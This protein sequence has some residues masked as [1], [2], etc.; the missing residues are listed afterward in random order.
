MP[1][2][3]QL[4]LVHLPCPRCDHDNAFEAAEVTGP[5]G[6]FCVECGSSFERGLLARI[7]DAL[8]KKPAHA[9]AAQIAQGKFTDNVHAP[10]SKAG[11]SPSSGWDLR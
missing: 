3:E 7:R 1:T 5:L 6:I 4:G 10:S 11:R 8:Q 9:N 2:G